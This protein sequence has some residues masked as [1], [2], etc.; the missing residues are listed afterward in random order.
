MSRLYL[1]SAAASVAALAGFMVYWIVTDGRSGDQFATCRTAAVAGGSGAIGGPFELV[2][3]TGR[4]VTDAEV[5]TRPSLIY[6]GY[7]FCPDVCP[8]DV[9]RNAVAADILQ[10]MG[11]EVQPV[12]VTVDPVRDTP[13]VLA[14]FVANMHPDM[15]GLTGTDEQVRAAVRAYRAFYQRQ[16]GQD[17]DFYL[18]DHSTFSYLVLPKHGF[19]EVFRREVSA[20]DLAA[21]MACFIG[22]G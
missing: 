21:R 14:R 3:H 6:F 16:P 17:D 22:A 2:D 18:I 20:D 4:T 19:V 5:L 10:E 15:V 1:I 9:D 11:L 13:E 12:F 8:L 7:T